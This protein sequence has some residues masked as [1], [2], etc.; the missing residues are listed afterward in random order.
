MIKLFNFFAFAIISL[1]LI[2]CAPRFGPS[3]DDVNVL[4][5]IYNSNPENTLSWDIRDPESARSWEGVELHRTGEVVKLNLVNKNIS[6]LPPDIGRLTSMQ[7]LVIH[8]HDIEV[9]PVAL[10]ELPFLEKLD[11]SFAN[12]LRVIPAEIGRLRRL[13]ALVLQFTTISA[14]PAEIGNITTLR[15]LYLN[16]N[17][18]T[19]IPH[20]FG[21]LENL[22][23]FHIYHNSNHLPPTV[24]PE[25]GRLRNLREFW[26]VP[27]GVGPGERFPILNVIC[28]L[29]TLHGTDI[30]IYPEYARCIVTP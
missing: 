13:E 26:I 21:Q 7:E 8:F 27:E 24:P 30:D 23:I 29:E 4:I 1:L 10:F 11:L 12:E 22:K 3:I 6:V 5:A 15:S 17:G 16:N 14:V 25:I 18:I 2:G 20:E 9:I 28:E 19:S